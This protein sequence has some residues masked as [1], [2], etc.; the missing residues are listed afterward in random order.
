[1]SQRSGRL[2]LIQQNDVHG[3]LDAHWEHFRRGG[4]EEY[5]RV[6]GVARAAAVVERI[7]KESGAVLFVD[8]GDA[9][10]GSLAAVKTEGNASMAALEAE[11]I[12]LL[13]PGNWEYGYG[14]D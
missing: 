10:H 1:M 6:G 5:R 7:R 12:D 14:P 3:Q 9:I 8:C 2:T 13:I 4:K 11:H